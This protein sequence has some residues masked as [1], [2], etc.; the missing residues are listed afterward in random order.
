M[1]SGNIDSFLKLFNQL[2][3]LDLEEDASAT[4]LFAQQGAAQ[5]S[6]GS[7]LGQIR[8]ANQVAQETDEN[9]MFI[10]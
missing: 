4:R 1:P 2:I 10:Q 8:L 9:F 7:I 6:T 3:Q 5:T